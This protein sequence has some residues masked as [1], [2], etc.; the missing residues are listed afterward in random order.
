M[1]YVVMH[2]GGTGSSVQGNRGTRTIPQVPGWLPCREGAA[3]QAISQARIRT[4][5][6]VEMEGV[7]L[8]DTQYQDTVPRSTSA[9]LNHRAPLNQKCP[10]QPNSL[11]TTCAYHAAD[12]VLCVPSREQVNGIRVVFV[13]HIHGVDLRKET[14]AW[15]LIGVVELCP[16]SIGISIRIVFVFVFVSV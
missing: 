7:L 12:P 15:V 14:L 3:S 11:H 5:F 1:S 16:I 8:Q 4:H 13:Q 6:Q 2:K 9:P 10:A